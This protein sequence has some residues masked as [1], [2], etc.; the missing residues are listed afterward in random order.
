[1][2]VFVFVCM[3]ACMHACVHA[4]ICMYVRYVC[5]MYVCT[6]ACASACMHMHVVCMYVCVCVCVCMHAC[7]CVRGW[8]HAYIQAGARLCVCVDE[9]GKE[10]TYECMLNTSCMHLNAKEVRYLLV[11]FSLKRRISVFQRKL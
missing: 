6:R 3:R 10:G 11:A 9:L 1:M 7:D 5:I 2:Y 4:C 8:M